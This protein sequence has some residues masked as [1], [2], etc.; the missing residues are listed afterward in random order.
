MNALY[1]LNYLMAASLVAL[2]GLELGLAFLYLFSYKKHNSKIPESFRHLWGMVGTFAVFYL[3]NLE[4][5]YPKILATLAS[6]YEVPLILA[7]ILIL[8]KNPFAAF[9]YHLHGSKREIVFRKIYAAA[10]VL[11]VLLVSGILTS[12]FTGISII[13]TSQVNLASMLFNPFNIFVFLLISALALFSAYSRKIGKFIGPSVLLIAVFAA[14]IISYPY[15]FGGNVNM[16]GEITNSGVILT[17]NFIVAAIGYSL[18]L[19]V[20]LLSRKVSKSPERKNTGTKR[21]R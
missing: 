9:S 12:A 1:I 11:S 17:I 15:M 16:L 18:L 7:A 8:F 13:G 5:T 21:K 10:T 4:A 3:I 20:F 6:I 19:T 2:M 14:G